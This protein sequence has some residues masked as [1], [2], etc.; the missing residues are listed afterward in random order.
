MSAQPQ[1]TEAAAE[2]VHINLLPGSGEEQNNLNHAISGTDATSFCSDRNHR[3]LAICSI[4]CG[5]SC[6]GCK[7]LVYSVKAEEATD[8]QRAAEFSQRAKRFGIIAILSWVTLLVSIPI[9]MAL[10]SYLL[11]LLD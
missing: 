4:I 6:I 3:K 2:E 1:T 8:P 10:I 5:L 9:L 7:A 11:T